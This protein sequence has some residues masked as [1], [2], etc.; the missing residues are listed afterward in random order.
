MIIVGYF[1]MV[2]LCLAFVDSKFAP[3]GDMHSFY[4]VKDLKDQSTVVLLIS[5]IPC[6]KYF[7]LFC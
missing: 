5:D 7:K 4:K 3:S 1:E 6:G 2:R